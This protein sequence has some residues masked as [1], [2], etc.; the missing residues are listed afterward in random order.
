VALRLFVAFELPEHLRR[1]VGE[2]VAATRRELPPARWVRPEG[3]HLTLKFLGD[4]EL[5]RL[6]DL[7]AGLAAAFAAAPPMAARLAGEG[8]YP[9][10]RPARVA[11]L[12]LSLDGGADA[13]AALHRRVEEVARDAAGVAPEDR[14]FSPHV[15]LARCDPPWRPAAVAAFGR[16]FAGLPAEPFPLAAGALIESRLGPGGSRYTALAH[17]PVAGAAVRA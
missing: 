2:R 16:A 3:L 14:P 5:S 17:F 4:T 10:G 11:W 12:G 9:P 8:C 7:S 13:L 15:T 1:A 6:P